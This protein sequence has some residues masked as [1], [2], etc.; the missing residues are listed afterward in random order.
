MTDNLTVGCGAEGGGP[1]FGRHT[2]LQVL[3]GYVV[4]G[5]FR[6]DFMGLEPQRRIA[7]MERLLPYVVP[8]LKSVGAGEAFEE[9]EPD[10][11]AILRAVARE[12]AERTLSGGY[13]GTVDGDGD[14]DAVVWE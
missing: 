6:E 12:E 13:D 4:S 9:P 14:G 7:L 8:K 11:T 10:F 5:A 3:E 2:L 1:A